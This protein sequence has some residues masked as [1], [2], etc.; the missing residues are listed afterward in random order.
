MPP[1]ALPPP[2][3][4]LLNEC[5]EIALG[6]AYATLPRREFYGYELAIFN[7]AEGVVLRDRLESH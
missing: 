5:S 3:A 2:R 4:V 7:P 1:A 6:N